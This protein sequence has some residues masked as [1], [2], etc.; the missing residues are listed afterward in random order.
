MS[1]ACIALLAS[2]HHPRRSQRSALP[3]P[4]SRSGPVLVAVEAECRRHPWLP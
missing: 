3:F 2:K 1:A 4:A